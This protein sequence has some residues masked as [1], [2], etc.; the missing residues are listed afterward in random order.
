MGVRIFSLF[1]RRKKLEE[2]ANEI[3][4]TLIKMKPSAAKGTYLKSISISSTMSGGVRIEPK[5]VSA[6]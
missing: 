4:Q 5:S 1:F 6:G 3:L 2:N